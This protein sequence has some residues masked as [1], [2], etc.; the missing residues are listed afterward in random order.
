MLTVKI[1]IVTATKTTT[2]TATHYVT[3]EY[4]A[5]CQ[6]IGYTLCAIHNITDNAHVGRIVT[7]AAEQGAFFG[8]CGTFADENDTVITAHIVKG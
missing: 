4:T 5:L 1:R 7:L 6:A 2:K 3:D 8:N